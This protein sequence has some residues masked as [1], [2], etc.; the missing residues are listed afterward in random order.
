MKLWEVSDKIEVILAE[1]VDRETGEIEPEAEKQLD[2]LQLERRK[3]VFEIARYIKGE[4]AEAFAILNEADKL[5]KRAKS[6][7]SRAMWLEAYLEKHVHAEEKY[8]DPTV[9]VHWKQ[10]TA[11]KLEWPE[12]MD[13]A[14]VDPSYL[15]VKEIRSVDKAKALK[16]LREGTRIRGLV[17]EKRSRLKID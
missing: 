7:R 1:C 9:K 12:E 8:E 2:D 4:H 15:R 6:H 13:H 11:V 16:V 17:L 5:V 10:S 14:H 3:L